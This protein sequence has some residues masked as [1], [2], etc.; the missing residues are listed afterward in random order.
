MLLGGLLILRL[1]LFALLTE[2]LVRCLHLLLIVSEVTLD[3]DLFFA[4]EHNYNFRHAASVFEQVWQG[5]VGLLTLLPPV[6]IY[7]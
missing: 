4:P 7:N 6:T 5:V 1:L 2:T 3:G